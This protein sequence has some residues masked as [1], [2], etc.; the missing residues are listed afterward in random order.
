MLTAIAIAAKIRIYA[1]KTD[2]THA[3]RYLFLQQDIPV[4][5]Q[6]LIDGIC[7]SAS[8]FLSDIRRKSSY[9]FNAGRFITKA[10]AIP[11]NTGLETEMIL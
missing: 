5:M 6:Q 9:I 3:L 10:R 2:A 11:I 7:L 4:L 8:I 1:V